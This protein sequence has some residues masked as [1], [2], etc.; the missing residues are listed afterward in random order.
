MTMGRVKGK[1]I[2]MMIMTILCERLL[3]MRTM[4]RMMRRGR[5]MRMMPNSSTPTKS[6]QS[7]GLRASRLNKMNRS[8]PW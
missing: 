6:L 7:I 1:R 5:M 8:P 4:G 3:K 2:M